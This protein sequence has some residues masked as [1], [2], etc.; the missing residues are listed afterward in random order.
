MGEL[1]ERCGGWHL[2]YYWFTGKKGESYKIASCAGDDGLAI[3]NSGEYSTSMA[4]FIEEKT[5]K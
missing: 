2:L 5:G 1:P 4:R 3:F